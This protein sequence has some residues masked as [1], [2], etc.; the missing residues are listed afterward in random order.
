MK[1]ENII[2]DCQMV[3]AREGGTWKNCHNASGQSK[4]KVR[5]LRS[6][7]VLTYLPMAPDLVLLCYVM[8]V[9]VHDSFI[10][11]EIIRIF[12]RLEFLCHKHGNRF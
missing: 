3:K 10:V 12:L 2:T 11:P 1:T 8:V 6:A 5:L 9:S 4:I 7:M